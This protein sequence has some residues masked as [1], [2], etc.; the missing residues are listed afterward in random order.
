M[1]ETYPNQHIII[2]KK[3]GCNN[4]F[5]Q[6]NNEEWK[7][8]A[9]LFDKKFGAFKLY[10]YLASLP[11]EESWGLSKVALENELGFKKDAYYNAIKVL[12]EY[13]YLVETEKGQFE[14]YSTPK[15]NSCADELKA[16]TINSC[17]D[18]NKVNTFVFDF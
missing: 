8:A 18:E 4:N 2:N 13:G 16:N 17:A 7:T 14:F 10:L 11:L 9:K 15:Q 5:L 3:T 6:I 1:G 12:R